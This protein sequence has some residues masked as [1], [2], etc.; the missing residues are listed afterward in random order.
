ME[1]VRMIY[2]HNGSM[3]ATDEIGVTRAH[4]CETKFYGDDLNSIVDCFRTFLGLVGYARETIDE[5]IPPRE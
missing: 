2:E 1:R 5:A 3:T 4:E